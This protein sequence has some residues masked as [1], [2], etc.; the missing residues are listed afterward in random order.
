MA[1]MLLNTGPG[2]GNSLVKRKKTCYNSHSIP[3]ILLGHHLNIRRL[4]A[5]QPRY[6]PQIRSGLK[7][8]QPRLR[9]ISYTTLIAIMGV[10]YA[11]CYSSPSRHVNHPLRQQP[12]LSEES[13]VNDEKETRPVPKK[14]TTTNGPPIQ[15]YGAILIDAVSGQVLYEHNADLPRPMASTTKIMTALLFCEHVPD[16]GIVTASKT[17]SETRESSVHLKPG[18]RLS[19]HDLLRAM[20][21]RSANDACV[22][23]AEHVAGTEQNFAMEMNTRAAE[24]GA[25]HTHF[26][27]SHGLHNPLHYTTARDLALIARAAMQNPRIEEVVRTQRCRIDRS[28][29]KDDRTL[30]NHS[31]FLGHFPGADGIKTGYTIPAGHCY[32]GSATWG[33][34]R[35]ISVVLHSPNYVQETASLMNYGFHHFE[36]HPVVSPGDNVGD[37]PVK[38][39]VQPTVP[40]TVK[41]PLDIVSRAGENPAIEKKLLWKNLTAPVK[42]GEEV[43]S[44]VARVNGKNVCFTAL[45]ATAPVAQTKVSQLLKRTESSGWF[46]ITLSIIAVCLVSLGYATRTEFQSTSFAKSA[47][48]CWSRITTR[49]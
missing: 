36:Q 30:R 39:G 45:I 12:L 40:V 3:M 13:A 33:K 19:A 21:M 2:I 37:C 24:L 14:M 23:A 31:H 20:L 27:N 41:N 22:A 11:L 25:A 5:I 32:V 49:L 29:D 26:T 43:G 47:R 15:A 35:L 34:W 48:S 16:N 28:I 38:D 44:F 1:L 10:S 7:R 17:A 42:A 4:L 8:R 18:E 9:V 6:A 46:G